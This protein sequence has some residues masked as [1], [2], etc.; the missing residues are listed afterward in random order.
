[1]KID[2]VIT[3]N[4]EKKSITLTEEEAKNL[5]YKLKLIFDEKEVPFFPN[6]PYPNYPEI[7]YSCSKSV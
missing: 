3:F 1:M 7:T 6:W 2:L 5:F 4:I